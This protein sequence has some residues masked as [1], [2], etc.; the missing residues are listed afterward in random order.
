MAAKLLGTHGTCGVVE[1]PRK[2]ASLMS[3][4]SPHSFW[5]TT[6]TSRLEQG[7]PMH[8]AQFIAGDAEPRKTTSYVRR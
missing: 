4:L 6:I 8:N 2:N 3:Q 7:Q 1:R 5:V